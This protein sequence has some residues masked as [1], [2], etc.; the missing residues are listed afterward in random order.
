MLLRVYTCE[1]LSVHSVVMFG[2][3][4]KHGKH[5]KH[6]NQATKGNQV[7]Q[8]NQGRGAVRAHTGRVQDL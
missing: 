3:K 7:S 5:G 1:T 6:D 2:G 4:G 8:V